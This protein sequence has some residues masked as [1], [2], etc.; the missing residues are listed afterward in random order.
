MPILPNPTPSDPV[1]DGA[2]PVDELPDAFDPLDLNHDGIVDEDEAFV[3]DG[4]G[5]HPT[6]TTFAETTIMTSPSYGPEYTVPTSKSYHIPFTSA[7]MIKYNAEVGDNLSFNNSP[8]PQEWGAYGPRP[9]YV[10][11]SWSD[12]SKIL[13]VWVDGFIPQYSWDWESPIT[14]NGYVNLCPTIIFASVGGVFID[15]KPTYY[16]FVEVYNDFQAYHGY[17]NYDYAADGWPAI[18]W[19]GMIKV[20]HSNFGLSQRPRDR[21]TYE[22]WFDVTYGHRWSYAAPVT[23]KETRISTA[24]VP[25]RFRTKDSGHSLYPRGLQPESELAP[26]PTP[27]AKFTSGITPGRQGVTVY[28]NTGQNSNANSTTLT[29]TRNKPWL[30]FAD[31]VCPGGWAGTYSTQLAS[32]QK[33]G[34]SLSIMK[35]GETNNA[36]FSLSYVGASDDPWYPDPNFVTYSG[37]L[38]V[39]LSTQLVGYIGPRSYDGNGAFIITSPYGVTSIAPYAQVDGKDSV[40]VP[41][42]GGI[43]GIAKVC[44][45]SQM[46]FVYDSSIGDYGQVTWA[47]MV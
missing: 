14:G 27:L 13:D 9:D 7:E 43:E 18:S 4:T 38:A 17:D 11:R 36:W 30:F 26:N 10:G 42:P 25:S 24:T 41:A 19:P 16:F 6:R 40:L 45:N 46:A 8:E 29:V 47:S 35:K 31:G 37:M 5:L 2:D 28:R 44:P 20:V 3:S 1:D 34:S 23:V 32:Q 12:G 39:G 33:A 15:A 21:V 22:Q